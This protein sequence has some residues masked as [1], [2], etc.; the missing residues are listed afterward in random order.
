MYARQATIRSTRPLEPTR[1]R[2]PPRWPG[3][4]MGT[5]VHLQ[6]VAL[7]LRYDRAQVRQAAF[8]TLSNSVQKASTHFL[9][10]LSISIFQAA[11]KQRSNNVQAVF[12]QLS[13]RFHTAFTHLS[14][15]SFH[16]HCFH[17][18]PAG[19]LLRRGRLLRRAD[20]RRGHGRRLQGSYSHR[21]RPHSPHANLHK[22]KEHALR[23]RKRAAARPANS[24]GSGGR[25]P[26][27]GSLAPPSA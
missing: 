5:L 18:R 24:G 15:S 11:L 22:I 13:H 21:I 8:K 27:C 4:V 23:Q 25:R 20:H 6:L 9:K 17:T 12:K 2:L 10:Q 16:I 3:A 14:N 19:F 7:K 1:E 26:S